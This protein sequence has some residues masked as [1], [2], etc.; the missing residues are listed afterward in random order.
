MVIEFRHSMN[1]TTDLTLEERL[2]FTEEYQAIFGDQALDM[3]YRLKIIEKFIDN[4]NKPHLFYQVLKNFLFTI[5]SQDPTKFHY[6][7][8]RKSLAE[9]DEKALNNTHAIDLLARALVET[10]NKFNKRLK[11]PNALDKL[12][13]D[14]RKIDPN[15]NETLSYYLDFVDFPEA[16][17]DF[18]KQFFEKNG[19]SIWDNIYFKILKSIG[20]EGRKRSKE[21]IEKINKKND[22]WDQQFWFKNSA[23]GEP[24]FHS[25][26]LIILASILWEDDVK[27]RINFSN[28][29]VPA[30]TTSVQTPISKMLSP[31]NKVIKRD[32]DI[33]LFHEDS[34]IGVVQ[35][36]TIPENFF[37]TVFNGMEKLNSVT[38]H[39]LMRH[40]V[41]TAFDQM[42]EGHS[43][44]RVLNLDRGAKEIVDRLGL[45]AHNAITVVKEI[46]HAMAY[47]EFRDLQISGNL[48]QLTKYKSPIT[49]RK[50]EGYLITI[51][52]PL[53]PYKTFDAYK[54]G[55]C[56]LLIP[57]LKDPPLVNP[58][59]YHA[60]QYLLQMNIM[61]EFSKQ[62]IQLVTDGVIQI[63]ENQWKKSAQLCGLTS[64]I[65]PKI[66]DRWTQDGNNGAKFLERVEDDF[67]TL[68]Y[69]Y[70][71]ELE[72][73]KR[74]GK[75]RINQSN[76]GKASNIKKIKAKQR[77]KTKQ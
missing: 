62:S 58:N 15:R 71:K 76:R 3:L 48:I 51:G 77:K 59:Q 40:L 14:C 20:P 75:L 66:Q 47:F 44:Y 57:L 43:D 29:N 46:V 39:R 45:S 73:L 27:K 36:P 6:E 11:L 38:G 63:T 35:I 34:L 72:F 21:F 25:P 23:S 50:D 65:L 70:E 17:E 18:E 49:G 52:T 55:D 64:E 74:Q 33:Q 53:L 9:N 10:C 22:G 60:A 32:N 31:K 1:N 26:A 7:I 12:I 2:N 67:Y 13:N 41:L 4:K 37:P 16:N 54:N 56:G 68:G 5:S 69:E 61:G 24:F 30:L 8:V 42:V 19:L 28:Q